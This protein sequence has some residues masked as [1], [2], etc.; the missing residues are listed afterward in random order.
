M[1]SSFNNKGLGHQIRPFYFKKMAKSS[2][3]V[4]SL[5][6]RSTLVITRYSVLFLNDIRLSRVVYRISYF[7]SFCFSF[8][9]IL[10]IVSSHLFDNAMIQ[11]FLG[12][13]EIIK[14]I[15]NISCDVAANLGSIPGALVSS[16]ELVVNRLL[17]VYCQGTKLRGK[18]G[19]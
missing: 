14:V 5:Q 17:E 6:S 11:V 7:V 4:T 19:A 1:F 15:R 3:Y 9:N 8:D 12:H 2:C 10:K 18:V 16:L 13:C